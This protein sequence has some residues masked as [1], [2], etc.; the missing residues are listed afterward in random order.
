MHPA[1]A[2]A[3]LLLAETALKIGEIETGRGYCAQ[4]AALR[5]SHPK[6]GSP[7]FD[8]AL[9]GLSGR[10]DAAV[11][12]SKS[13]GFLLI[14]SWGYGFWSD[15][16]HVIGALLLAEMTGRTPV[17]HWGGNSYFSDDEGGGTPFE[18]FS[19]LW[20]RCPRRRCGTRPKISIP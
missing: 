9:Q 1:F 17:V 8:A 15:V 2:W 20:H 14:K 5:Q 10:M 3:Y 12:H 19:N 6:Q 4:A 13:G 11:P 18:P 16:E 7:D